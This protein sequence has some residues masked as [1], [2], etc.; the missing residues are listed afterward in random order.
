MVTVADTYRFPVFSIHRLFTHATA[1]GAPNEDIDTLK[2]LISENPIFG[3]LNN[4]AQDSDTQHGHLLLIHPVPG[5]AVTLI[6]EIWQ[7]WRYLG[8]ENMDLEFQFPEPG[9]EEPV[10]TDPDR[11]HGRRDR[12]EPR[13]AQRGQ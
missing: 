8:G 2:R 7:L 10:D 5:P 3:P 4:D 6:E 1:D 13:D 9:P 12:P 11:E